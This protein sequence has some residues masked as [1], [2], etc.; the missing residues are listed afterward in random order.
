[1]F[2]YRR[3]HFQFYVVMLLAIVALLR[4]IPTL[5]HYSDIVSDILSAS[6][7][8]IYILTFFLDFPGI[9]SDI[10]YLASIQF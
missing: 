3:M 2:D 8:G 7:H 4:V 10:F 5:T 1:M 9:Y 6:I